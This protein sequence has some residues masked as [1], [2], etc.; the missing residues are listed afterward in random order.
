MAT[1]HTKNVYE[2]SDKAN[3]RSIQI[4]DTQI[5]VIILSNQIK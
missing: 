3:I 5:V 4:E 2:K 1:L